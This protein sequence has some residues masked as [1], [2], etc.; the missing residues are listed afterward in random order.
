MYQ[1]KEKFD[2]SDDDDDKL[3]W[4]LLILM[5]TNLVQLE[6]CLLN[7]LIYGILELFFTLASAKMIPSSFQ[8]EIFARKQ[9]LLSNF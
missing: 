2:F 5:K 1:I 4:Y 6:F 9:I 3:V 7:I 8:E